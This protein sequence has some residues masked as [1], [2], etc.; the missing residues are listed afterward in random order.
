ML[1][2]TI[3][4]YF[5]SCWKVVSWTSSRW[6][7]NSI[8]LRLDKESIHSKL[9][10]LLSM[11]SYTHVINCMGELG[12][13]LDVHENALLINSYLPRLLDGYAKIY[14][15]QFYH[16]GTNGIFSGK[17][18]PYAIDDI[19][20]DT[21]LYGWS[22]Y[23]WEVQ[24]K[25]SITLRTSIVWIDELIGKWFINW[26]LSQPDWSTISGFNNVLWNGVTTLT[27]ARIIEASIDWK[28]TTEEHIL[29][30]VW[31][32]ISKH[33]MAKLV[34]RIFK[35]NINILSDSTRTENRT[36]TPYPIDN[37]LNS[38]ISPLEVQFRDL[39]EFHSQYLL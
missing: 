34:A 37:N 26:V 12:S 11:G 21:S 33:D 29:Q 24:G 31:E 13:Q 3:Y 14:N 39:L 36:L 18:W 30:I 5:I 23:L 20:D 7:N 28:L 38:Y 8:P 27:L 16:I 6:D 15:F 32:T 35:K 25:N 4:R 9:E 1:W 19:P 22:K 10:E 2:N 17:N